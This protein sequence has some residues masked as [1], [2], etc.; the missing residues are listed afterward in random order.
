M[1]W[2]FPPG[3][4][5]ALPTRLSHLYRCLRLLGLRRGH[6]SAMVSVPLVT[7]LGRGQYSN[8][9]PIVLAVAVWGERWLNRHVLIRSDNWAVVEI[10]KCRT[11][12]DSQIMHL[13]RCL[14]FFCAKY[15]VRVTAWHIPQSH[16]CWSASTHQGRANKKYS[17]TRSQF[18]CQTELIIAKLTSISYQSL[19]FLGCQ[20]ICTFHSPTD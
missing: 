18:S 3:S 17:S 1:E 19:I 2:G 6:R 13:L 5:C 12:R 20:L 10:L 15:N 9:I 8:Q 11:S 4:P 14:H 16:L 7:I